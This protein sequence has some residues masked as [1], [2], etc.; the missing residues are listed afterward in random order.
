MKRVRLTI[1]LVMLVSTIG[2]GLV[3][4]SQTAKADEGT[5]ECN[6]TDGWTKRAGLIYYDQGYHCMPDGC[7]VITEVQ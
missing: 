6:C 4:L 2:L 3:C 7:Y 1:S 5:M